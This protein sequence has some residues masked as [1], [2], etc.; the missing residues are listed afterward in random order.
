MRHIPS[1]S[2]LKAFEAAA[3]QASFQGAANE[4]NLTPGAISQKIRSLEEFFGKKLFERGHKRVRPTALGRD[5]LADIRGPLGQ[6]A[7]ASC[8]ICELE[9]NSTVSI[10]AYP[11]FAIRWLIPRWGALYDLY[12]NIDIRLT[13]S[14]NVAEFTSGHY[15]LT[16][17]VQGDRAMRDG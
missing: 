17:Q 9:K 11:T 3:R 10:C 14:L 6:L 15:D 16:I 8:R 4:L 1:L 13:T 5:Y 7:N 2:A 12:P